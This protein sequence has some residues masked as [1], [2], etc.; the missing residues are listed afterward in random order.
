MLETTRLNKPMKEFIE[1]EQADHLPTPDA[2]KMS[3]P[4]RSIVVAPPLFGINV[5]WPHDQIFSYLGEINETTDIALVVLS[6]IC[7]FCAALLDWRQFRESN[8]LLTMSFEKMQDEIDLAWKSKKQLQQ[9]SHIHFDHADKLKRF[10]SEKLIEQIEYDD[11][12]LHF[13]NI[14]AEIRHNGVISYDIVR[15]ALE[16]AVT[17]DNDQPMSLEALSDTHRFGIPGNPNSGSQQALAAMKYLWDLLDLST[18]DN[19][20]LHIGNHLIECEETYYQIELGNIERKTDSPLFIPVNGLLKAMAPLLRSDSLSLLI[21]KASKLEHQEIIF[22]EQ[23]Y[24]FALAPTD[25]LLGNEN[26]FML[27]AENLIRNAQYFS[28]KAPYKQKTDR[29]TISLNQENSRIKLSV[30]NR[31]PHVRDEDKEAIFRLGHSTR[32]V[33]KHHGRGLGLFFVNEIVKGYQGRLDVENINNKEDTFSVRLHTHQG[34]VYTRVLRSDFS[35]AKPA[36]QD[37]ASPEVLD[38]AEW[39]VEDQLQTIEVTSSLNQTT[40]SYLLDKSNHRHHFIDEY[41]TYASSWLLE[42]TYQGG[43]SQVRFYPLDLAGVCFHAQLPSA[44]SCL[45]IEDTEPEP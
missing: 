2:P 37:L 6:A 41:A 19:I 20:A 23:I 9:R 39:I 29:I 12:F 44:E 3:F 15:T 4:W 36:L 28:N 25:H 30:Y 35:G 8:R 32:R 45:T 24:R 31:G 7:F 16:N 18:T 33:K 13:K 21:D 26:H 38:F 17:S 1:T 34:E 10:I 42:V 40:Q 43:E 5:L 14:A 11:K 27:V 22:L